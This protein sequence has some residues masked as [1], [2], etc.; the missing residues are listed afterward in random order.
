L[1]S[2]FSAHIEKKKS[3]CDYRFE[4]DLTPDEIATIEKK[5]NEI[6]NADL[7]INESFMERG[8]RP[9]SLH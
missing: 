9:R 5:V 7:S 8:R 2:A 3:K 4:R 1:R 6:I